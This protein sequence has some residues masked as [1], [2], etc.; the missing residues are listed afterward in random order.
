MEKGDV[1]S[2]IKLEELELA[3]FLKDVNRIAMENHI[4]NVLD[5][6]AE[7]LPSNIS[8]DSV[9]TMIDGTHE[10]SWILAK[11]D[12]VS[13]GN[14]GTSVES[15]IH[16]K[17]IAASVSL[18]EQLGKDADLPL[19]VRNEKSCIPGGS[20]TASISDLFMGMLD[21]M[22]ALA[23][24]KDFS[25]FFF[26]LDSLLEHYLST[27]P[28][29][30]SCVSL[31]QSAKIKVAIASSIFL[32]VVDNEL[33]EE[34]FEGSA[35][36]VLLSGDATGIQK[37]IFGVNT[38]K[39]SVKLIR[40]RSFQVWIQSFLIAGHICN[41]LGLTNSNIISFSGGKFLLLLPNTK[42][43]NDVVE[44]TRFEV[45][46]LCLSEYSG[47]IAY[48]ISEGVRCSKKELEADNNS[49]IQRQ[50]RLDS[51]N[52][53]QKKLQSGINNSKERAVLTRQYESLMAAGHVC[54]ACESNPVDD[55]SDF[56]KGCGYLIELGRLLNK[57]G[58]D[59]Y[60]NFDIISN[61]KDTVR[62]RKSSE[63]NSSWK[64]FSISHYVPGMARISMPYY[65]PVDEKSEDVKTFEDL[66]LLS[67]GV[68]KLAMFK[69]DVD[70]LG[71]IFSSSLKDKW[72]LAR[73]ASLSSSFHFY[74]SEYLVSKVKREYR[75]LYVV[76]SGGDDVCIIGPWNEIMNFADEFNEDFH[77]F[78]ANN[79]SLSV[80]AGIVMFS[81]HDPISVVADEAEEALE[82]SKKEKD[83]NSISLFSRTVSWP[84]YSKQLGDADVLMAMSQLSKSGLLYKLLTYSDNACAVRNENI[85]VS[86]MR[87]AL[88]LSHYSYAIRRSQI[89]DERCSKLLRTYVNGDKMI[90]AK[91][92][93]TIALY[94]NRGGK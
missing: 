17:S 47:E 10:L 29:P 40:A 84:E 59:I 71:L 34:S 33:A 78:S 56:C 37:Y 23:D 91:I 16:L 31:Y 75:N 87:K 67:S 3:A 24:D 88:W 74:F 66:S 6:V 1:M 19:S 94:A 18:F 13:N 46:S 27:I 73:Y 61:L 86:D 77:S 57:Q 48:I 85:G 52:A 72:S 9:K 49:I 5:K 30:Y 81:P 80:S 43:L 54:A 14:D 82:A 92:A 62:I 89:K 51:G 69:A 38:Y 15:H 90:N 41:M 44:R 63:L 2:S 70:Y 53:K 20:D 64:G 65:V 79:P 60:L 28:S 39:H 12:E 7:V 50:M 83:K 58:Y 55:D 93:A 11:A 42:A 36:F 22:S 76:F 4:D 21:D 35:P 68:H 25:S 8:I 32:Y 26:A 45:D